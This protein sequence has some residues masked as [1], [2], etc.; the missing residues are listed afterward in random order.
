[1]SGGSHN[2]I[3][4]RIEEELV[5]SM[6]DR[7]LDDL[8]QDVANLAHDLEWY[9][10]SDTCEETYRKAVAAFKKKWFGSSR[11]DRLRVYV[12]DAVDALRAELRS[13]IGGKT[14]ESN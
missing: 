1:M 7:E 11:D 10:S 6:E 3:C 5:G 13:M 12:D 2:Y 4:Y 14:N 8:M 9:H